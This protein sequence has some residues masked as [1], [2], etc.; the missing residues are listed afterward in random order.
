MEK[1][2]DLRKEEASSNSRLSRFSENSR[3]S[4]V[5]SLKQKRERAQRLRES[6]AAS[7]TPVIQGDYKLRGLD[8]CYFCGDKFDIG[9]KIPRILI[10]CGHTFC[11]ECLSTLHNFDRVRCPICR[12]LVKQLESIDKLP[13]NFNILHEIVE[14]DGNL[15]DLNFDDDDC[16]ECLEC[17]RHDQRIR[18]FYCGNH[19]KV[20]CRECMKEDHSNGTCFVVDLYEIEKMRKMHKVNILQNQNQL[21]KRM[22]GC[23]H[24]MIT[25]DVPS[26][27]VRGDPKWFIKEKREQLLAELK[28]REEAKLKKLAAENTQVGPLNSE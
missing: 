26:S 1:K 8:Y 4:K 24:S 22:D 7:T 16:L 19:K 2:S 27:Q 28:A 5:E 9:E 11:T 20:F 6:G 21:K 13:L 3:C 10:H 18:H 15:R 23:T 17:V 25:L 12:K 14:R